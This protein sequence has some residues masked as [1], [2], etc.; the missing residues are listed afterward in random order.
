MQRDLHP[1]TPPPV[2]PSETSLFLDFDGTLVHLAD[3]P[4]AVIVDAGLGGLLDALIRRFAGRVAVVSGRS[5]A[6]LQQML[7]ASAGKLALVGSHGAEVRPL[8]M[9]PN[10]FERPRALRDAEALFAG[11]FADNSRVIIEVKTLGVAIHYRLD[12]SAEAEANGLAD[13]FAAVHGLHVQKGKMMVELRAPGHDK[14]DGIAELM[15]L[16]PFRGFAPVFIGDDV[17][18][19][20]GFARCREMGG[21]GILVGPSRPTAAEYRLSDVAAVHAW[22]QSL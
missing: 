15:K 8:G 1:G 2:R 19:E 16:D 13:A 18:D 20:P 5:I 17:T 12:P 10:A 22:L 14:G 7:G 4:D 11:S 21:F 3:R 9:A 6:Q